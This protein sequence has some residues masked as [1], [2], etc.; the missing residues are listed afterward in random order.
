MIEEKDA[1]T[2]GQKDGWLGRR[3]EGLTGVDGQVDMVLV[4]ILLVYYG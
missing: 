2:G 4:C 1:Q 3:A